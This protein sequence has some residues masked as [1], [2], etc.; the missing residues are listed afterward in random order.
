MSAQVVSLC[1]VRYSWDLTV[2]LRGFLG[3]ALFASGRSRRLRSADLLCEADSTAVGCF[4]ALVCLCRGAAV[5]R[6]LVG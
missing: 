6:V 1:R 4:W 2:L 5:F 3:V